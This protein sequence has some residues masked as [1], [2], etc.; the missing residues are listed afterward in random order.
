MC[1]TAGTLLYVIVRPVCRDSSAAYS[2]K[3]QAASPLAGA[4]RAG[5]RVL[6]ISGQRAAE[7]VWGLARWTERR[8]DEVQQA[9][10]VY[11]E[12]RTS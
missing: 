4:F 6:L 12:A 11:D 10:A 1:A 7:Q 5:D 2:A 9:R 3:D 8:L